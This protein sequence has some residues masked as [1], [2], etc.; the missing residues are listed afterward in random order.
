MPNVYG[1]IT[2]DAVNM[3]PSPVGHESTQAESPLDRVT[4]HI[5]AYPSG[6][7]LALLLLSIYFSL[8]LVALDRA[9]IAT[10]LPKITDEFQSFGDTGWVRD[11]S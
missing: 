4:S 1:V 9:I 2:R 6:L 8:S 10:T 7:R 3:S 5:E 11:T